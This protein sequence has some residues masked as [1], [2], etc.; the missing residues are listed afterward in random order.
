MRPEN[1]PNVQ[2]DLA[3]IVNAPTH[4]I[5][6]PTAQPPSLPESR[7]SRERDEAPPKSPSVFSLRF[8]RAAPRFLL[9]LQ[10]GARGTSVAFPSRCPD[11]SCVSDPQRPHRGL[12]PDAATTTQRPASLPLVCGVTLK[13]WVDLPR[14]PGN[15]TS[16]RG[17][18]TESC[19]IGVSESSS[20]SERSLCG[21]F[22]THFAD[23]RASTS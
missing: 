19:G 11:S 14:S 2:L 6:L 9:G 20:S 3:D 1:Q 13:T 22:S 10:N 18:C 23:E 21:C 8:L 12:T 17:A 15:G 5:P 16:E 4:G 7:L